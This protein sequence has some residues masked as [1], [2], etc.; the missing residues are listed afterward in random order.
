[1]RLKV[2]IVKV[3]IQELL[4]GDNSGAAMFLCSARTLKAKIEK[5]PGTPAQDVG[6]DPCVREGDAIMRQIL[7][8]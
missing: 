7:G 1:M 8:Y 2:S 6:Y 5:S 4:C 3:L